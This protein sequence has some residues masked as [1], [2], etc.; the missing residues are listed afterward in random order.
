MYTK[1][2]I[3]REVKKIIHLSDIHIRLY[4]RM[5]EYN[6]VFEN[7]YKMLNDIV[8]ENTVIMITGDLVHTK[9]EMSPESIYTAVKLLEN[10]ANIAPVII[11]AGNHDA[12]LNNINR[13]DAIT[14]IVRQFE[15]HDVSKYTLNYLKTGGVY[16]I[17]N[18][19]LT[20]MSVFDDADKYIQA[21]SI[22]SDDLTVK[23]ATFHG[24]VNGSKVGDY[25]MTNGT[26]SVPFF[27]G[28][29]CVLLGDIHMRQTL[30]QYD[31][32]ANKPLIAYAGSLIQQ[33]Y[34]E[35]LDK[36]GFLVWDI[37]NKSITEYDVPN[38]YGY[39]T[40]SINTPNYNIDFGALCRYP[41]VRITVENLDIEQKKQ[42][43]DAFRDKYSPVE[44]SL[45]SKD[46][47]LTEQSSS[48]QYNIQDIRQVDYQT[49]LIIK[50]MQKNFEMT[51]EEIEIVR[52]LNTVYNNKLPYYE[53]SKNVLWKLKEFKFS[54]MFSYGPDNMIVFDKLNGIVGLFA[55]NHTGKSSIIDALAY[56]L[57]DRCSRTNKAFDVLN[58]KSKEFD[59]YL[60]LEVNGNEYEIMRHGILKK[61][62]AITVKTEFNRIE[63]D[64][65]RI[66]V[67][68]EQRRD[69]NSNIM[70]II[71]TYEDFML[72]CASS[73]DRPL[74][75][76][77]RTQSERKD[78]IL[79]FLDLQ[80]FDNLH[81]IA[82]DDLKDFH[83]FVSEYKKKN[84]DDEL[85]RVARYKEKY[86]EELIVE[87]GTQKKLQ[88][89][90]TSIDNRLLETTALIERV[91]GG[92]TDIN[93]LTEKK[94]NIERYI[95]TYTQQE[96]SIDAKIQAS[97]DATEDV[98][99]SIAE[100]DIAEINSKLQDYT[101]IKDTHTNLNL[102][103]AE[104]KQIVR[105]KLDKT[106]KLRSLEY[107][108]NCTFCMNNVFVKDA[109][110][111]KQELEQ[112]KNDV[113]AIKA[114]R[115]EAAK[116]VETLENYVVLKTEFDEL[117]KKKTNLSS[118]HSALLTQKNS[119][120]KN[121]FQYRNS[122]KQVENDIE[123]FNRNVEILSRN[124]KLKEIINK[125]SEDKKEINKQ[126]SDVETK[127]SNLKANLLLQDNMEKTILG[128]IET[129]K[130]WVAKNEA[131]SKYIATVSR[132]GLPYDIISEIMPLVESEVNSMLRQ[133]A[134]YTVKIETTNN[135]IAV[136]VSYESNERTWISD[137][138]SGMEKFVLNLAFR[139][140][141]LNLSALSRTDFLLIDEGFGTLDAE[142]SS[143]LPSLFSYLKDK[144]KFVLII[145]HVDHIR[146][147]VDDFLDIR[148]VNSFSEVFYD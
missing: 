8:D 58:N 28:Y 139:V 94:N 136:N 127:I 66:S 27:D 37:E 36:H 45:I 55:P 138:L 73:Q 11:T 106:E 101:K 29:D 13:L 35:T 2:N 96:E 15:E 147:Y 79:A 125:L 104:I 100:Y 109:I 18:M 131:C 107:D 22:V 32:D 97:L 46:M 148:Q 26:I 44:F 48:I 59:A 91:T 72:T 71:G 5:D 4:K 75:F 133:M 85:K 65:T 39:Y 14:P 130:T 1:L 12:N 19:S 51:K 111:A 43:E 126:L 61:D 118:A 86:N 140:A 9:I 3:N 49:D 20:V 82:K 34:A 93:V 120:D 105:D 77:Q 88:E 23:I 142:S 10:L 115:D 60:R 57:F 143:S 78:L 76:L 146:D 122:L 56:T 53:R 6:S 124:A 116:S 84:Y 41:R 42:L 31:S 92:E 117:Y 68:G 144:F 132:D 38:N 70:R 128:E 112:Y 119:I 87:Y 129:Y 114:K 33:G 81:A 50:F 95:A 89:Q 108:P 135:N 103:F 134:D 102:K 24:V 40:F 113:L 145:S 67:N 64:G 47:S 74:N 25:A 30:Q 17:N 137:M 90:K 83:Y 7:M 62:S 99:K 121:L 21:E 52:D 69:T 63:S 54:N 110:V 98:E 141:L 80:F 16:T 123:Q